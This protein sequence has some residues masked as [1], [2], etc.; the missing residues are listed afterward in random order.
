MIGTFMERQLLFNRF[1]DDV[2]KNTKFAID[3]FLKL[4]D[5]QFNWHSQQEKWSIGQCIQHINMISRHWHK[6]FE[7][8][9]KGGIKSENNTEYNS[10]F[11][12]KYIL[13]VITPVA[14]KKFKTPN[15]FQP[16][17]LVN[18][19]V[20]MDDFLDFQK[21][22]VDLAEKLRNYDLEKNKLDSTI[23]PIIQIKLGDAFEINSRHTTRH[24]NQALNV[25]HE[26]N[27]PKG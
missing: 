10:G 25:M 8:V 9:L 24:L 27:F 14:T 13:K 12:G 26:K 17:F 22:F 18:G 19:K 4:S 21:R 7:K 3:H 23:Y 20:A 2:E 15:L 1:K 6:Q 11:L 16:H 5:S